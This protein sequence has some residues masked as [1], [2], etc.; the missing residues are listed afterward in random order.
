[1]YPTP[2]FR[3]IEQPVHKIVEAVNPGYYA[4]PAAASVSVSAAAKAR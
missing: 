1:V 3:A 4:A 2:L